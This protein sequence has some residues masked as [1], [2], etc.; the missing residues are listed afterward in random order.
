VSLCF[1]NRAAYR[2]GTVTK[3]FTGAPACT[4]QS[5]HA[6]FADFRRAGHFP[7]SRLP[8]RCTCRRLRPFTALGL[9]P[10]RR[11]PLIKS[12]S[13]KRKNPPGVSRGGAMHGRLPYFR[14]EGPGSAVTLERR[15]FLLST[16][17]SYCFFMDILLAVP[18][19]GKCLGCRGPSAANGRCWLSPEAIRNKQSAGVWGGI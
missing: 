4:L 17:F 1:S 5:W 11:Q 9:L 10:D 7:D 19:F 3:R 12:V 6:P 13:L 15:S 14:T 2:E 18:Q 16:G 8:G